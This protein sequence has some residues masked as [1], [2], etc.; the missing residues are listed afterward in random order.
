MTPPP[1]THRYVISLFLG[2]R[3]FL[4]LMSKE[5]KKRGKELRGDDCSHAQR[6]EILWNRHVQ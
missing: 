2:F 4:E 5:E 1:N 3:F 6:V